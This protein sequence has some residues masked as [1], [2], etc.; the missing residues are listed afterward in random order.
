MSL[1][2]KQLKTWRSY[3]VCEKVLKILSLKSLQ[4]RFN[5]ARKIQEIQ[6]KFKE[7]AWVQFLFTLKVLDGRW[8]SSLENRYLY[9]KSVKLSF[10]LMNIAPIN[11]LIDFGKFIFKEKHKKNKWKQSTI[12]QHPKLNE[13]QTLFKQEQK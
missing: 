7:S 9:W 6:E 3:L 5:W 1:Q 13:Q 11:S 8:I 4:M 2:Q 12:F 10:D